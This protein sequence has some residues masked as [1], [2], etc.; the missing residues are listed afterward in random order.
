M[1][2]FLF[3]FLT[4]CKQGQN[5]LEIRATSIQKGESD[6][7]THRRW[8]AWWGVSGYITICLSEQVW[9]VGR[10][11]QRGL[12]AD[13]IAAAFRFFNSMEQN[14]AY[15]CTGYVTAWILSPF[16]WAR[17]EGGELR[18]PKP[19]YPALPFRSEIKR[20]WRW[21]GRGPRDGCRCPPSLSSRFQLPVAGYCCSVRSGRTQMWRFSP[22]CLGQARCCIGHFL[23]SGSKSFPRTRPCMY[24]H[25][26][27]SSRSMC[28]F[29]MWSKCKLQGLN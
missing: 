8:G 22:D 23:A 19:S 14:T 21:Q 13:C 28:F 29:S 17:E 25:S 12:K 5:P 9:A 7:V 6:V 10:S 2:W 27:V 18:L 15:D 20:R 4:C 24:L 11:V 3:Y 1:E 26:K 16:H